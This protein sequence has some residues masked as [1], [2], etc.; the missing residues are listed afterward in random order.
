V[1]LDA[2]APAGGAVV[3]LSS[4]LRDLAASLPTVTV[5]AGQ[6]SASFTVATNPNYRRYSG[7]PFSV[8]ITASADGTPVS[9]TLNVTAQP[10]PPDF[11]S[12][13]Q[14]SSN[15][16][17]EGLM[18]GDIAPIGGEAGILYECSRASGT[19]FGSCTFVQECD[20]GCRRVPPTGGQFKEFSDFCATS[21]PNP[22]SI[23]SSYIVGGDR[24]PGSVILEA[25]AGSAPALEQGVP[26]TIDPNFNSTRFPQVGISFPLGATSVSFDVATSYV[27]AI[28]FVNVVAHWFNDAIPPFL[29]TNGRA[30]QTWLVML[31]PASPPSVAMPT[32]GD[33]RITGVN[34]IIGGERALGQLDLSGLSR[35]GGPTITLT[36]SHPDVVPPMTFDAPAS[37]Q[38]FGFQVFIPTNPPAQDTDVT[39]TA[40]D[41]RYSFSTVLRVL[42]PPPPPVLSG[43]SVNPGSVVG[44]DA[45]TGTV[46]L[47]APQPG[48]TVVQV[49]IIDS[50]PATLP[51]NDP[52]CPPS[53]RCHNV[54]VPAGAM[55]ANFTIATSPVSMQFNLNIS[56]HLEGSPGQSAL[57][58]ILPNAD[59]TLSSLSLNPSTVVGGSSSTGMVT[60]S[61]AAPSGG[62]AVSLVSSDTSVASVP[63]SVTVPAGATSA[64]FTVTTAAVATDR[65]VTLTALSNNTG[66]TADLRVTAAG[67]VPAFRNPTANAAD[68][69]GDRNGFESNPASA[70]GDDTLN[71]VDTNSG[72]GTSTSCTSTAKD[73]HRFFNYGFS[74]PA[75]AAI[76]GIEVR[77]DARADSTAGSP[78][79]CVQLSWDGGATWTTARA[80]GTLGTSMSTFV[81]GSQTDTWGRTWTPA[82]LSD[83][84]FRVRVINVASSTSRDF[85][86]DWVAVRVTYSGGGSSTPS[87]SPTPIAPS[88]TPVSTATPTSTPASA[89]PTRTPTQAPA[90]DTVS[91]QRAEYDAGKQEL[92]VEA[93]STNTS[94]AVQV[95]VTS[96]NALIGTLQNDGGGRYSGRFSW[97]SNPQ[98]ITV[99]SS[100]GGSATRTVALN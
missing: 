83:A 36:S 47:S 7:L 64:A 100:L 81:L 5:P 62:A 18:C 87:A 90:S 79:M 66:R 93:T 70:H 61:A 49:S 4:S 57:L 67:G 82:N 59:P 74:L 54:T 37:N 76:A 40:T 39:I 97:P 11:N 38:L 2:P 3:T 33:F 92:R 78:R 24:I 23:S 88:A 52:P 95:F 20:L 9:T 80:T 45:A 58:L 32:L 12:G 98:S 94:A 44:G 28:Q 16:Q 22:V 77:L 65:I 86:L 73:K 6:T 48:P 13:S 31:P 17:W 89:T 25:P 1:T 21:G 69:G 72:S 60:L 10:R 42:A 43:I 15:T 96:T 63:A 84:S 34:P 41:G 27:P 19:G 91:I 14:A 71:A 99:R 56:A 53:S 8:T 68:S 30:G 26:R 46:T 29:I 75:G 35:V 50:A 55:S 85:F 51:S